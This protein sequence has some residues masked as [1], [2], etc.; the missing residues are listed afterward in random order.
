MNK[1]CEWGAVFGMLE[2]DGMRWVDRRREARGVRL[3]DGIVDADDSVDGMLC[4]IGII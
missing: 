4:G 1:G 2:W 3:R